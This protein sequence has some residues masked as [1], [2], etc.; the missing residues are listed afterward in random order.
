M[1]DVEMTIIA[2]IVIIFKASYLLHNVINVFGCV[3]DIIGGNCWPSIAESAQA[4]CV[5]QY[6]E[7]VVETINLWCWPSINVL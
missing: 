3:A 6:L 5:I 1:I 4:T 7:E 2:C